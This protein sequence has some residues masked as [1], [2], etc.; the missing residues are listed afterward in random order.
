M[1][2]IFKQNSMNAL[3]FKFLRVMPC[4]LSDKS[5]DLKTQICKQKWVSWQQFL[6]DHAAKLIMS[7]VNLFRV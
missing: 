4:Q 5:A 3:G 1:N 2:N 7:G 6:L